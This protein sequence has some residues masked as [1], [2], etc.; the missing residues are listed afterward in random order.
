MIATTDIVNHDQAFVQ[1]YQSHPN[2][3]ALP[4]SN[5][6]TTITQQFLNSPYQFEPLGEGHTG[7][8]SHLPLYRAD[9]FD[10]VSFVDTTLALSNAANF[11]Q[12]KKNIIAI[13]YTNQKVDYTQRTDWFTDYEWNP[14]LQQLGYIQDV[15]P[16]FMDSNKKPI[17]EEA[18][19]I[20]N[21]P[22][23]YAQKTLSNLELP[24]LSDEKKQQRL[25][26]LK[27]EGENF[28]AQPS[29]LSYLPLTKLFDAHGEPVL[30]LWNQFP[31]V[32]V[33]EIV[34][35]NWRPLNPKDPSIDYGTNLNVAHVGIAIHT[36]HGV[37][38]YHASS[39]SHK[40]VCLPLIDYLHSFLEDSRSAPVKGIH[41]EEILK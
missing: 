2:L 35:P 12:F 23:F 20:I 6:I 11:A 24:D 1:F 32:A 39:V 17:A 25:A 8:Y 19:T 16:K 34:R 37:M 36:T 18:K 9:A 10:C 13:R 29:T 5:R 3:L 38:I 15:T 33:I 14:H 26:Q 21:K 40:V 27:A 30:A 41:V 31:P 22:E 7:I 28:T 4:L